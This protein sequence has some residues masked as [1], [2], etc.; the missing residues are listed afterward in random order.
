[1]KSGSKRWT[2]KAAPDTFSDEPVI[3]TNKENVSEKQYMAVMRRVLANRP[4]L[5]HDTKDQKKLHD[6]KLL[7]ADNIIAQM[8]TNWA[9]IDR[10]FEREEPFKGQYEFN[11]QSPPG[12]SARGAIV[13]SQD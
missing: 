6:L 5:G 9:T 1:M 11:I 8:V 4:L 3:T 7:V 12:T 13:Y 10:H 2:S